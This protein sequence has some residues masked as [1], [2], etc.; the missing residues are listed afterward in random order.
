MTTLTCDSPQG[1]RHVGQ[2]VGDQFVKTVS[3]SKHLHRVLNA[4]AIDAETIETLPATVRGIT[5]KE[6]EEGKTY[7]VSL[8]TF[9]EKAIS[10]DFGYGRQLFLPLE[11]WM[12]E[13]PRQP[14]LFAIAQS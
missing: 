1:K 3:K 10:R 8:E 7:R 5:I 4:W 14:P 2:I 6:R 13:D 11:Y 9:R 12:V